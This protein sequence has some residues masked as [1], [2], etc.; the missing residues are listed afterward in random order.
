MFLTCSRVQH[1]K[2]L[3]KSNYTLRF[4][5]NYGTW[6]LFMDKCIFCPMGEPSIWKS[7]WI[8]NEMNN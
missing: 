8:Q 6:G 2:M 3:I 5:T 7:D 1:S 4:L